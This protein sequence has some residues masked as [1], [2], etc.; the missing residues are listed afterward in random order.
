MAVIRGRVLDADGTTPKRG[1]TVTIL[2]HPE[3]GQTRTRESGEYDLAV[4]GGTTYVVAI[5]APHY[6]PVQRPAKVGWHGWA[7]VDDSC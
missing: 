3:Y 6:L 5:Q 2:G 1:A 7:V 4:N